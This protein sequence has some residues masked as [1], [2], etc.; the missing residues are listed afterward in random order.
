MPGSGLD[1]WVPPVAPP[2]PSE[3]DNWRSPVLRDYQKPGLQEVLR[4]RK[5]TVTWATGAGKS[6]LGMRLVTELK[7]PCV[8]LVNTIK[9]L[10]QWVERL[11]SFCNIEAGVWYGERKERRLVTISTYQSLYNHVEFIE[12]ASVLIFDEGDLAVAN[13]WGAL[14]EAASRGNHDYVLLLTATWPQDPHKSMA[15][16]ELL[17]LIHSYQPSELRRVGAIVP[18]EPIQVEVSLTERETEHYTNIKEAMEKAEKVLHTNILRDI[19][20]IAN[21]PLPPEG[22]PNREAASVRVD[23]AWRYIRL[24]TGRRQLLAN[25]ENKVPALL[26]IIQRHAGEKVLVFSD[27]IVT[28]ERAQSYLERQGVQMRLLTGK[29][30]QGERRTLFEDWGKG[31][32]VLGAAKVVDRGLDVPDVG[33]LVIIGSGSSR[34]QITQRVGRALRPS[35]GKE[36]AYVYVVY[37]GNTSE[38]RVYDAVRRVISA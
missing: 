24:I 30:P 9:L 2:S 14:V 4:Q 17:P 18:A 25:A 23:A 3:T 10:E 22:D 31:Y 15:L 26:P 12:D 33:V 36:R 19:S 37:C 11:R 20:V 13:H 16:S 5:G 21:R 1:A 7:R 35:P 34:I 38:K 8:I 29:T 27:L 6:V 28:L 32:Q